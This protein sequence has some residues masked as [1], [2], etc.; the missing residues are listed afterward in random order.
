M[1][2]KASRIVATVMLII[3]VCFAGYALG[4]PEASFPW[5]NVITLGMIIVY[6]AALIILFIA[7]FKRQ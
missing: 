4:H 5:S 6:L 2:K 7:P 3:A 1:T